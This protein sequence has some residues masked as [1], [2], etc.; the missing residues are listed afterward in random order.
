VAHEEALAVLHRSHHSDLDFDTM[1]LSNIKDLEQRRR[2]VDA[3][4]ATAVPWSV[5]GFELIVR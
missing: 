4:Q 1:I 5:P 3:L 2:L